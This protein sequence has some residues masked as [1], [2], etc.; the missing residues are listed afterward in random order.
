MA[1]SKYFLEEICFKHMQAER[2]MNEEEKGRH[3]I[4]DGE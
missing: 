3:D 1:L 4:S 2:V